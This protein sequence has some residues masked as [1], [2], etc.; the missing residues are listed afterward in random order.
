MTTQSARRRAFER[1]ECEIRYLKNSRE[2]D[3]AFELVG[4]FIVSVKAG[5]CRR[6][7]QGREGNGFS[8]FFYRRRDFSTRAATSR[9]KASR[10]F[11]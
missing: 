1:P 3:A 7:R 2:Y 10:T 9:V 8:P 4:I 6:V 5:V 11:L